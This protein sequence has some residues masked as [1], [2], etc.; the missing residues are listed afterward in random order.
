MDA[1]AQL[2]AS[3]RPRRLL[4]LSDCYLPDALWPPFH[5]NTMTTM[6]GAF[7][8]VLA[9]RT[10]VYFEDRSHVPRSPDHLNHF[11][12]IVRNFSPDV[13]FSI[14]RCGVPAEVVAAAGP[15][16]VITLFIDYFERF[17]PDL[18]RYTPGECVWLLGNRQLEESFRSTVGYRV[19]PDQLFVSHWCADHHAFFPTGR[20]R[21]TDA[22]YV[23]T[24]FSTHPFDEI[25]DLLRDDPQNR[26]AFLVV[27]AAHKRDYVY[28]WPAALRRNGF[29]IERIPESARVWFRDRH[30][31]QTAVCDQFTAEVRAR[32]LG[33]LAGL[34]LHIYG[35]PTLQWVRNMALVNSD[36][37]HHFQFRGVDDSAELARLY[38]G[39]KIGVNLQHDNARG[40]GLSF[41]VYEI[42][43][44][45]ALL[46]TH[47]DGTAAM[48]E[49]GFVPGVDF[50]DFSEPFE[51]REK[52]D[53]F[54]THDAERLAM[55]EGAYR[56][57]RAGHTVAQRLAEMFA[58]FGDSDLSAR[59]RG[60]AATES[61]PPGIDTRVR[62]IPDRPP[63]AE[64]VQQ[65]A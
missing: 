64:A 50:I 25:L 57:V 3:D 40:H 18:H 35:T 41:R 51:L 59:F 26:S 31:L 23:G 21:T 49:M 45:K 38:N 53:H 4:Y 29:V 47:A 12:Q 24:P 17:G 6:A 14:N 1:M 19:A 16:R 55:V 52:A 5:R 32:F 36:L 44:C 37:L 43:A 15:A 42:M 11:C 10:N 2:G 48:A 20:P 62:H 61:A 34:D 13:V 27:H 22:V 63:A 54:L 8:E 28:D 58:H 65:A 56:K 60:L 9:I 39:A 30:L 7:D 46:A 33:A